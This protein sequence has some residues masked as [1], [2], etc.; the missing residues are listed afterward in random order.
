MAEGAASGGHTLRVELVSPERLVWSGDASMVV[1]RIAGEGDVAF[2]AGHAP[3]LGLLTE[4]TGRIYAPDGSVQHLAVHGG[5]V[6]VSQ[7]LV[8]ILSDGA[9]LAEHIDIDRAR[10]ANARAESALVHG[11][12]TEMEAALRRAH[13]RLAAAGIGDATVAPKPH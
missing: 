6:E 10:E 4:H 12:D 1:L 9:E 5:F 13:A 7:S 2:Q 3:F 8:S 11:H